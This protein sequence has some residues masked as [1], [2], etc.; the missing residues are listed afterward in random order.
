[1]I[2]KVHSF[3]SDMTIRLSILT[4]FQNCAEDVMC[5]SDEDLAIYNWSYSLYSLVYGSYSLYSLI[6]G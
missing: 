2:I 3:I 4:F 1:M 5:S 6:Y